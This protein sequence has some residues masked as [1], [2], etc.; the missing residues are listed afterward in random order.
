M[1]NPGLVNFAGTLPRQG[2]A[3]EYGA[4]GEEG[5]GFGGKLEGVVDEWIHCESAFPKKPFLLALKMYINPDE[6]AIA[7]LP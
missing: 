5:E 7:L 1:K 4:W 3:H 6:N 2:W